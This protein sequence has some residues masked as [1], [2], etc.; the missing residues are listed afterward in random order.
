MPNTTDGSYTP[1]PP[2]SSLLRAVAY[3]STEEYQDYCKKYN[4]STGFTD[5][6][7]Y[8]GHGECGSWQKKYEKMHKHDLEMLNGYKK[9]V[10]PLSVKYSERPRYISYVCTPI[11]ENSNRG[12]G[13]LGDRMNGKITFSFFFFFFFF[14]YPCFLLCIYSCI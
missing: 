3:A 8:N 10:F 1:P 6:W 9:G 13:G 12:C 5:E 14:L 4:P 2:D 7:S 11:L